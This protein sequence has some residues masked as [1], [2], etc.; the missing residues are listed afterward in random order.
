MALNGGCWESRCDS[1]CVC[2]YLEKV[3]VASEV[4]WKGGDP[5]LKRQ[6]GW[7]C[8]SQRDF[9]REIFGLVRAKSV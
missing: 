4:G 2:E 8:L 1:V 7:V 3:A 6:V 9:P 5:R